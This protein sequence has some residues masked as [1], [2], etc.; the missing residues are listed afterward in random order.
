M[1]I[2]CNNCNS[3]FIVSEDVIGEH[4]R[5]VRCS[6]CKNV[7]RA[8]IEKEKDNIPVYGNYEELNP[9]KKGSN[10]PVVSQNTPLKKKKLLL[11]T[12]LL[13]VLLLIGAFIIKNNMSDDSSSIILKNTTMRQV[14]RNNK[15]YILISANVVNQGEQSQNIPS[16]KIRLQDGSGK[17]VKKFKIAKSPVILHKDESFNYNFSIKDFPNNVEKVTINT[18]CWINNFVRKI[19]L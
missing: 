2:Q 15:S 8:Y 18:G 6:V 1:I 16:I 17:T 13:L 4:G 10:L 19:F 7:W 5:K 3:K 12:I 9:I 11:I 14:E